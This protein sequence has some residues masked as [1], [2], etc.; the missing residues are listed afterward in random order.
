M[1]APRLRKIMLAGLGAISLLLSIAQANTAVTPGVYTNPNITVGSD[2]RITSAAS[3]SSLSSV[4][5]IP[6]STTSG[7]G[8]NTTGTISASS[9]TLNLATAIDFVNGQGIRIN[10]AGA[11]F[12]L[13]PPTAASVTPT[14]TT[15]STSYAY[16]IASLNATGGVGV[17]ITNVTTPTGNATLSSTNYNAVS[18]TAP[19]GTAP[20][21][22][23]VYGRTAGSFT[24]LGIANGTTFNDTGGGAITAPDW[25]PIAPAGVS[26]ASWLITTISSGAGTTTLT[27]AANATTAATGQYVIHDDTANLQA[28][29]T[30]AQT[31]GNAAFLPPGSY[32]VT[33]PLSVTSRLTI[34]GAGYQG[35]SGQNNIGG[36]GSYNSAGNITSGSGWLGA[37]LICG[38]LNNCINVATNNAVTF[39]KFQITYPVRAVV[40]ITGIAA[41]AASGGTSNNTASTFRDIFISG[42]DIA[43]S[44]T[45]FINFTIDHCTLAPW[46]TSVQIGTPN[47]GSFGDSTITNSVMYGRNINAHILATSIGGLRI[48]NNK[49]VSGNI[50]IF[51]SATLIGN[52]YEPTIITGNS[53]EGQTQGIV[54]QHRDILLR[55]ADRQSVRTDHHHRKLNRGPDARNSRATAGKLDDPGLS[56]RHHRQSVLRR[57]I[58]H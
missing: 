31:A 52:Q 40:G 8:S 54:G 32:Q 35:D 5:A 57:G 13:N 23:A 17:T 15:G 25:L 30:T 55:N 10:H 46:T 19:T 4:F 22:Y 18:W 42:A 2:G 39:E 41:A 16:T 21:A 14:G 51:F 34:L 7:S 6:A 28:W 11:A 56:I 24:L 37:T 44:L 27:L 29:I 33:T 43:I 45:N 1:T 49:L 50:G 58:W 9:P 3:G 47:Y 20:A 53:I 36:S 38:A 26:L 48:V 12:T